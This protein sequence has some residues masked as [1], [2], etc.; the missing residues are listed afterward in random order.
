MQIKYLQCHEL[1]NV[2]DQNRP[3]L[4]IT[5]R[6]RSYNQRGVIVFFWEGGGGL[7]LLHFLLNGYCQLNFDKNYLTFIDTLNFS[8]GK[9]SILNDNRQTLDSTLY[10]I[11]SLHN[12]SSFRNIL[13]KVYL[14]KCTIQLIFYLPNAKLTL[15]NSKNSLLMVIFLLLYLPQ[16]T[17]HSSKKPFSKH[18]IIPILSNT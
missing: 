2:L 9:S 7:R 5:S 12:F 10:S 6:Q 3:I 17:R 4:F 18:K 8:V 15:K 14:L 11:F 1:G 16:H 13:R